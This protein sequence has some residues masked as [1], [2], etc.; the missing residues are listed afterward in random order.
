MLLHRK[1]LLEKTFNAKSN[2]SS[3]ISS[4]MGVMH[5]SSYGARLEVTLQNTDKDGLLEAY[6]ALLAL[7]DSIIKTHV[8]LSD[9]YDNGQIP[10]ES[11]RHSP[12]QVIDSRSLFSLASFQANLINNMF[13]A[14]FNCAIGN[15]MVPLS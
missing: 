12:I 1:K 5:G 13:T 11:L 14:L 6:Q 9:M 7:G 4:I 8:S 3:K 2:E 15:G 10:F